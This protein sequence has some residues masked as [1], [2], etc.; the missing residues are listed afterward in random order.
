M[1]KVLL[2]GMSGVGKSTVLKQLNEKGCLTLDLDLD[3]WIYYDVKEADYLMDITKI[4]NFITLNE[5]EIVFLAGT[6]INQKEIYP[7]L[8]CVITLTAP[9]EVMKERIQNREDN[10]FGK[11][12]IEWSKTV[13]DKETF[14]AQIIKSS[15]YTVSTDKPIQ[16]VLDEIYE[17]VGL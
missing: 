14:E 9:I 15:N 16:D 17:V 11:T 4:I 7:Y 6:A 13:N 10:P 3:G 8:G 1:L 12:E 2:T 5:E